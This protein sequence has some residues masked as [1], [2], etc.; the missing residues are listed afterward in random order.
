MI[1]IQGLNESEV[2]EIITMVVKNHKNKVFGIYD[3]KDIEQEAWIIALEKMGSFNFEKAKQKDIKKAFECWLNAVISN[4]LANLF[5][6]K[7]I[8]PQRSLKSD[9]SDVDQTK[10]INLM[11]PIDISSTSDSN[12]KTN[13]VSF[14]F[15]EI[16][17]IVDKLDS[18]NLDILDSILSGEKINCYY[19]NKLLKS[20]NKIKREIDGRK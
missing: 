10:R 2:I 16:K 15:N 6:D 3:Q 14:D 19:R 4:R 1:K 9:K 7:Y 20:I 5:R 17:D 18:D 11:H 13:F 12:L 8:V